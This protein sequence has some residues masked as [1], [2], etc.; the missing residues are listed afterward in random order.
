MEGKGTAVFLNVTNC[1]FHQAL[2]LWIVR[3]INISLGK[4]DESLPFIGVLDI[5]GECIMLLVY[6]LP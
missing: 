3:V 2:F 6:H 1:L 5:F 4:V